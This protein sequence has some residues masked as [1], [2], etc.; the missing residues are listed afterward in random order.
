MPQEQFSVVKPIPSMAPPIS[1]PSSPQEQSFT[2]TP[3]VTAKKRKKKDFQGEW[4]VSTIVG[5]WG[6][7]IAELVTGIPKLVPAIY[8]GFASM[9]KDVKFIFKSF[10][11]D[12]E[13]TS[14]IAGR[15]ALE[16]VPFAGSSYRDKDDNLS[17]ESIGKGIVKQG[18]LALLDALTV[19]QGATKAGI[20][21]SL[22][23][24]RAA[25][26]VGDINKA[27]KW[28]KRAARFEFL[29]AQP[30]EIMKRGLGAVE[31]LPPIRT[32]EKAFGYTPKGREIDRLY[33]SVLADTYSKGV[34]L[35]R[36]AIKTS[37]PKELHRSLDDIFQFKKAY[38]P[39][40][41]EHIPGANDRISKISDLT[42][43]YEKELMDAKVIKFS[44][45][46]EITEEA[47]HEGRINKLIAAR[48]RE[49]VAQKYNL[50][51]ADMELAL[52]KPAK[53]F[54]L[55]A[56]K[57]SKELAAKLKSDLESPRGPMIGG[58]VVNG[59]WEPNLFDDVDEATQRLEAKNHYSKVAAESEGYGG[60]DVQQGL[61]RPFT[62]GEFTP[63]GELVYETFA[64]AQGHSNQT[65]HNLNKAKLG[66]ILNHHPDVYNFN[67]ITQNARVLGNARAYSAIIAQE[68]K[69]MTFEELQ[70]LGG[71]VEGWRM[72]KM[73]LSTNLDHQALTTGLWRKHIGDLEG[74]QYGTPAYQEAVTK[75]IGK[76][77]NELD[78]AG[79][80]AKIT[81]LATKP[82]VTLLP[83]DVARVLEARLE[84]TGPFRFYDNIMDSLRDLMLNWTPRFYINNL[85][86]N[87]VLQ[88]IH[89]TNPFQ[90][91]TK[92]IANLPAEVARAAGFSLETGLAERVGL[93]NTMRKIR[94]FQRWASKTD[95]F[96]RAN[97][98][99]HELETILKRRAQLGELAK[100]FAELA[101]T[102]MKA[103]MKMANDARGT[104]LS[105]K[106]RLIA[107]A[108]GP[109]MRM[110][111]DKAK[112]IS[113]EIKNLAP[114]SSVAEEAVQKMETFL[115]AYGRLPTF[116]K[117]Y[118]RRFIH[119]F[120]TF[121]RTMHIL[122]AE[123]PFIRPGTTFLAHRMVEMAL[124]AVND[125]RLP[126]YLK[127]SVFVGVDSK[128]KDK[129]IFIRPNG[130][131]VFNSI[132]VRQVGGIKIPS[133][134]DPSNNFFVA[135]FLKSKGADDQFSLT[136]APMGLNSWTD[137]MGRSWAANAET[138]KVERISPQNPLLDILF[139][140]I[141][142][143]HIFNDILAAAGLPTLP[144]R[145][146]KL[147]KGI[148]GKPIS[149]PG[150]GSAIGRATGFP[151]YSTSKRR[152]AAE[153]AIRTNQAIKALVKRAMTEGDANTKAQV[154]K[155]AADFLRSQSK[156]QR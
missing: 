42:R 39:K 55:F 95:I 145:S 54:G 60:W 75:V 9:P 84:P 90:N 25:E 62:A 121:A 70:A 47:L 30:T 118:M 46:A 22:S 108:S 24:K 123:M 138:G 71:K 15:Q 122:A 26:A 120:W 102:D 141:P 57:N 12:P 144:G 92:E 140:L 77:A 78:E 81:E 103:L 68:G 131:D 151:V 76:I 101:S 114:I 53:F 65:A 66:S 79:I 133:I 5:G 8:N 113:Q 11:D 85:I 130:L 89:G 58:T 45:G 136:P 31:K 33:S 49:A 2:P 6:D 52:K 98:Y 139:E 109:D 35:A 80:E 72:T 147:I 40:E 116:E 96:P 107:E 87:S 119:P 150:F 149:P 110:G 21:F 38:N 23:A 124:D 28:G 20:K 82:R 154:L 88:V 61:Y 104:S 74:L 137:H 125:H 43:A 93:G 134:L 128:N 146:G 111:I 105:L 13:T 4:D 10:M 67:L 97:I 135:A 132:G 51:E 19:W 3:L 106:G 117:K 27:T 156:V 17:F 129:L 16:F 7:K 155:I 115:G 59:K 73:P 94:D 48:R 1:T 86:G 148:D 91:R 99:L 14:R 142:H 112:L 64:P 152:L 32:I 50:S 18:P 36:G 153:Q 41:W 34:D 69:T 83:D 44:S 143:T 126:Q 63:M 56:S 37:I 29:K 127:D 100:P